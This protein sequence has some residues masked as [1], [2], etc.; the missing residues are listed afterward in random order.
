MIKF[1]FLCVQNFI[2]PWRTG[3]RSHKTYKKATKLFRSWI[4][5][6][7]CRII[8]LKSFNYFFE[9]LQKITKAEIKLT[10]KRTSCLVLEDI[11]LRQLFNLFRWCKITVSMWKYYER[12]LVYTKS[13]VVIKT[14]SIS[15]IEVMTRSSLLCHRILETPRNSTNFQDLIG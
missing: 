10:K 13:H 12:S 1:S 6:P 14:R 15:V 11:K 2:H 8:F 9:K 7:C 5:T 4:S 3:Q